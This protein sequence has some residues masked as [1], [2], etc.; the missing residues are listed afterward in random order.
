MILYEL[1]A[2]HHHVLV[3]I[4]KSEKLKNNDTVNNIAE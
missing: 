3:A 1:E 4:A 2:M